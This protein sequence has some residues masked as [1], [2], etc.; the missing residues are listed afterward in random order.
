MRTAVNLTKRTPAAELQDLPDSLHWAVAD[1]SL[2]EAL[3]NEQPV[4]RGPRGERLHTLIRWADCLHLSGAVLLFV[5]LVE[6][7]VN[8][9][10]QG[11]V[12]EGPVAVRRFFVGF[13]AGP[14]EAL[15][16]NYLAEGEGQVARLS[17]VDLATFGPWRR[18]G[19]W[20]VLTV[21]RVAHRT[22]LEAVTRLPE[23]LASARLHFLTFAGMRIGSYSYVRAWC[24]GIR[25]SHPDLTE[26]CFLSADTPAFAAVDAGLPTRHLQHGFIRHSLLLPGFERVD[27]LTGD[28]AN[29]Y[30]RRLP[31]ARVKVTMSPHIAC[32]DLSQGILIASVYERRDEM[33]RILPF[34]E[35]TRTQGC[36]VWVRRHPR[37]EQSFWAGDSCV[38]RFQIEDGDANFLMALKRLR[39]RIVVSWYSTA[40]ADA[41]NCGIVPVTINDEKTPSVV[42]MVYPLLDR[43]LQWPRQQAHIARLMHDD[44]LYC[45]T[46]RALRGNNS[47]I[48]A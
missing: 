46:I 26:V 37:E 4:H 25:K 31:T 38:G 42:D 5:G 2:L 23:S 22:A 16:L 13:G 40:L 24:E 15:Y 3:A 34:L 45:E 6:A 28:E 10:R 14:E 7:L 35:W 18:V 32:K 19:L 27:A 20:Q 9:R 17:Q 41:L 33:L 36:A 11:S 47:E 48:Y 44:D 29:H 1:S 43:A 8:W 39:P 30:R 12:R 21:L